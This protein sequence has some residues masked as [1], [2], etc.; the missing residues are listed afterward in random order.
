MSGQKRYRDVPIPNYDDVEM[1][2]SKSKQHEM[3]AFTTNWDHKKITKAVFRGGPSGCGYTSETNM[4]IKLAEMKSEYLDVGITGN[5][6]S[7]NSKAIKFDPKYGLG[8][9]NLNLKPVKRLSMAEQ[10]NYKYIIHI[11]GNVNAYRLLTTM[12]TGSLILRVGSEYRSW[13]D[14][15]IEPGLHYVSVKSDLS[16]LHS[17]IR[18]CMKNDTLCRQIAD[19]GRELATSLLQ[20]EYMKNHFQNIFWFFSKYQ[21][22]PKQAK[23]KPIPPPSLP[24]PPYPKLNIK[25]KGKPVVQPSSP[26][27]PPPP[28]PPPPL[29]Y[30][31]SP[32][33]PPPALQKNTEIIHKKWKLPSSSP[34]QPPSPSSP[35]PPKTKKY[36][37]PRIQPPSP[38]T[39]PTPDK[40][41][42]SSPD[43]TTP[44]LKRKPNGKTKKGGYVIGSSSSARSTRSRRSRRMRSR[45]IEQLVF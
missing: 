38:P 25:K 14:H 40:Y 2:M 1:A 36:I 3:K 7:I 10:S 15:M 19:A 8:M 24:Y 4:R 45:N 22:P 23:T 29:A 43:D 12:C 39:P 17:C 42:I 13:V 21:S 41:D 9:M 35:P 20:K 6:D 27:T 18:S 37:K 28:P 11:D 26:T 44:H 5:S 31:G 34:Q 32:Q 33:Y 30:P 16:D